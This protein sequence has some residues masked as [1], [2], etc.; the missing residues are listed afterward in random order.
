MRRGSWSAIAPDDTLV[1][2]FGSYGYKS[3]VPH[4]QTALELAALAALLGADR[5][6]E[7]Q[8]GEW[9]LVH[10][11]TAEG[12]VWTGGSFGVVA[13]ALDPEVT[14]RVHREDLRAVEPERPARPVPEVRPALRVVPH[15]RPAQCDPPERKPWADD[16]RVGSIYVSRQAD[17]ACRV[18]LV[19]TVDG[20]PKQVQVS[21]GLLPED[22]DGAIELCARRLGAEVK[23]RSG[24][25]PGLAGES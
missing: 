25:V 8:A 20:R 6:A 15:A 10:K 14:V 11:A 9:R 7:L 5:A 1:I 13:S 22:V 12:R 21:S 16:E 4:P 2:V 24:T 18:A 3:D 17:G 23:R 19:M